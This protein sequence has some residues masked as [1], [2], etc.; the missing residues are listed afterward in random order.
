MAK[1]SSQFFQA[2]LIICDGY[3][4]VDSQTIIYCVLIY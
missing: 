2:V 4:E 3:A 1:V